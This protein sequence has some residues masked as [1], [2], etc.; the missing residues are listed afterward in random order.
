MKTYTTNAGKELSMPM[1]AYK[2]SDLEEMDVSSVESALFFNKFAA[3][4]TVPIIDEAVRKDMVV[5]NYPDV[6]QVTYSDEH[7]RMALE[8]QIGGKPDMLIIP[9]FKKETRYDTIRRLKVA[10]EIRDRTRMDIIFEISYNADIPIEDLV[11]HGIAYDVVWVHFGSHYMQPPA[12]YKIAN[13][14]I[15]IR[16]LTN[17]PVQT[18]GVPILF[19]GDQPGES[20][21][22]PCW[23][24][25]SDGWIKCWRKG[26]SQN[27]AIRAIDPKDH[28][29]KTREGWLKSGYTLGTEIKMIGRTV[30]ELFKDSKEGEDARNALRREVLN[31][32]LMEVKQV[33]PATMESYV[34]EKFAKSYL[35]PIIALY[36]EKLVAEN[37]FENHELNYLTQ[38]DK[39]LLANSLRKNVSPA[40][41]QNQ[42]RNVMELL[43]SQGQVPVDALITE[44]ERTGAEA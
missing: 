34:G 24:L 42:I 19:K 12:F 27:A 17:H 8:K 10:K 25:I 22:M 32:T 3:S 30:M 2:K 40:I 18:S 14:I 37:I 23:P 29:N 9:T 4:K 38:D 16:R 7:L 26:G 20:V 44:V 28:K 6:T 39:L 21:L 13:W 11:S 41:L 15:S 33:S 5:V 43:K 35:Y 1:R 31:E 36:S